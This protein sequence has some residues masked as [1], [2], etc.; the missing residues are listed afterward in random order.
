MSQEPQNIYD[1][2]VFFAGYAELRQNPLSWNIMVV[3]PARDALLPPLAG[4]RVADL[5]CGTGGFC[6]KAV[7][8]GAADVIG[9]DISER[10]L[11]AARAAPV[12]PDNTPRLRYVRASLD[13]WVAP[14]ETA[15]VIV[16]TLALH[17]LQDITPAF[18]TVAHVLAPGGVFLFCVEHPIV[19]ARHGDASGW[20]RDEAHVKVYWALDDYADEGERVGEWFVPGMRTYHRTLATYLNAA[21]EV[22]L[23]VTRVAEPLPDDATIAVY[24]AFADLRR[25]PAYL[26]V[27]AIKA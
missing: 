8:D 1:D 7:A 14:A 18:A 19:T 23:T 3:D 25:R 16:S 15:D 13:A 24:P 6:R 4:K 21:P 5:G 26:F 17:Y 10:M 2:P 27:R 22:G 11:D 20:I 12:N 9:V